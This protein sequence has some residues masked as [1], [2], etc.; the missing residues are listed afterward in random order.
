V[1]KWW[2]KQASMETH[3]A[4]SDKIDEE[5]NLK[6]KIEALIYFKNWAGLNA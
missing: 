4:Q 1:E 5:L 6:K 2:Y 3:K